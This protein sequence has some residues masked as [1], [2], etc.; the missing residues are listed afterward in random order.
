MRFVL[1]ILVVS[2]GCT[3]N[4]NQIDQAKE[5]VNPVQPKKVITPQEIDQPNYVESHNDTLSNPVEFCDITY[6][7]VDSL[8]R[9]PG[10]KMELAKHI[11]ELY[12]PI[13]CADSR[14]TVIG[15]V[16]NKKGK[17]IGGRHN[18]FTGNCMDQLNL[19]LGEMSNWIPGNIGGEPVC[20][21]IEINV[22]ELL[23]EANHK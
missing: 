11:I 4:N 19:K 5:V 12:R 10:G 23:E 21:Q 6:R 17:V 20:V 1:F 9:F 3:P 16:I 8:P 7:E 18:G 13:K 14:L 15:L 22:I 2:M